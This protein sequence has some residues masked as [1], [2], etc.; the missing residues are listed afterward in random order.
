MSRYRDILESYLK[1]L[2]IKADS[3]L[4]V[5]GAAKPVK[6]RVKSWDV[7]EY[8]I[9]DNGLE[10]IGYNYKG[11]LNNFLGKLRA[12]LIYSEISVDIVFDIAFCLEVFE[13]IYNPVQ[14]V[15]NLNDLLKNNGIL[16]ITFPSTYP[17]HNP[18]GFDYLRYTKQGATKLL[19]SNGFKIINIFPR[20]MA[21]PMLYMQHLKAE[22]YKYRGGEEAGTL[23]DAGYIIEAQKI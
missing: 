15:K 3:V 6:D 21:D 7:K 5:G 9:L 11:D 14:A 1:T 2:E 4:D 17:P 20:R 8:K 22:G 10:N 18:I 13:Y 19:E 12:L 16:Y 23:F